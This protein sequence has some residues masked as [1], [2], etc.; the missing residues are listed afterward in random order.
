MLIISDLHGVI[1][2]TSSI[3]ELRSKLAKQLYGIQIAPKTF[4]RKE[5]LQ[6]NLLTEGQYRQICGKV[7]GEWQYV[8]RM[9]EV[10]GISHATQ[11][12]SR[13]GGIEV[14]ILTT[15][16]GKM[17][18]CAKKWL[19]EHQIDYK[20]IIGVGLDGDRQSLLE[21]FKPDIYIDDKPETLISLEDKKIK[22]LLFDW[23]YN[24]GIDVPKVGRVSNWQDILKIAGV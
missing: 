17:L 11:K 10:K 20:D 18:D 8:Q 2:D 13:R 4:F 14:I 16:T 5:V 12:L 22:L 19:K 1:I 24:K 3:L 15:V 7:Y 6:N 9:Q 21:S 23:W